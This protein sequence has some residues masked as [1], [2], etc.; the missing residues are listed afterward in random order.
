MAAWMRTTNLENPTRSGGNE[1]A[2]TLTEITEVYFYKGRTRALA[3]EKPFP[4]SCAL[5]RQGGTAGWCQCAFRQ[6]LG[7]YVTLVLTAEYFHCTF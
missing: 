2:V 4:C 3:L 7:V 1:G 6:K 5:G